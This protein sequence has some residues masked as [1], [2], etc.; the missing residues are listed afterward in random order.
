MKPHSHHAAVSRVVRGLALC[1]AVF[2][3]AGCGS[4]Q[5]DLQEWMQTTRKNMPINV[6]KLSEPKVFA[7]YQYSSTGTTDPYSPQK[8]KVGL[9]AERKAQGPVPDLTRPREAL[10]A[11][12]LDSL[13]MVGNLV[14]NG[15]VV[16][17]VMADRLLFQVRV[18]EHVGQNFGRITK[19]SEEEISIRELVQ[20]AA[21]DW[22]EREAALKLQA[23]EGSK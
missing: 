5:S 20:D 7:P 3:L 1:A 17:L 23:Q 8:L 12:P 4:D 2:A 9:N 14:K 16:A 6:E 15:Q 11:Y 13:R 19:V 18:G 22:V 21:G 10:E